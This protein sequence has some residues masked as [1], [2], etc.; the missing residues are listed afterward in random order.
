AD[1][2]LLLARADAGALPLQPETIDL[3][4]LLESTVERWRPAAIGRGVRLESELPL[5][6]EVRADPELL[7]RLL[8]NLRDNALR[9]TPSGGTVTVSASTGGDGTVRIAVED[10]GPGIAPELRP[11]LFERFA[12]AD[13]ARG[14]G[15]GGAGLGL[16]LSAAIAAAHGGSLALDPSRP[17]ARFV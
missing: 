6:A 4:D 15:T 9:H 7:R 8:D 1:Q 2:L 12:R 17:G 14:R 3:P 11:R 13:P 5:A 16:S 10:T